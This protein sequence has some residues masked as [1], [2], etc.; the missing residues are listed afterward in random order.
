ML[1][2][3]AGSI[4]AQPTIKII[5]RKRMKIIIS[6]H[7]YRRAKERAGWKKSTLKRYAEH[8]YKNS[9]KSNSNK[10]SDDSVLCYYR[11]FVFIFSEKDKYKI[12]ILKTV[13]SS[14]EKEDYDKDPDLDM[15]IKKMHERRSSIGRRNIRRQP[16]NI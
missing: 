10:Q 3:K 14:V 6:S 9:Y 5:K 2:D 15:Q 16:K 7:A 1:K 13:F 8:A 4:P 11:D 12:A